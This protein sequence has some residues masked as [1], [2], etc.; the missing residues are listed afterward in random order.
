[1]SS[2]WI[3]PVILVPG[4]P[5]FDKTQ[6]PIGCIETAEGIYRIRLGTGQ[7][8]R[9]VRPRDLPEGW[10]LIS[11]Q[12]VS[13]DGKIR[14]TWDLG[15]RG[16]DRLLARIKVE[17][18]GLVPVALVEASPL[19]FG[20]KCDWK[21]GQVLLFDTETFG[22][23][24]NSG[25]EPLIEGEQS[26]GA[27]ATALNKPALVAG[28]VTTRCTLGRSYVTPRSDGIQFVAKQPADG[29]ILLP[30][31]SRQFEW[32]FAS[33]GKRPTQE[34]ELLG[35]LMAHFNKPR[36][37]H[38]PFATWCTW[39]SSMVW[40][41]SAN[42]ELERFVLDQ[43][44]ELQPYRPLGLKTVRV[45]EDAPYWGR[46]D[47][48]LITDGLPSGYPSIAKSAQAHGFSVGAWFDNTRSLVTTDAAQKHPGWF[49]KGPG[50]NPLRRET[51][52]CPG[53]WCKKSAF[54]ALTV[55]F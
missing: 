4:I 50:G 45:V 7:A 47:Y 22:Y 23:N 35:S 20:L 49:A 29:A 6:A 12:A 30:G 27:F 54:S 25:L 46:I 31:R 8:V 14:L 32:L 38:K 2:I 52:S 10:I 36:L 39:Y 19:S 21:G 11:R 15:S 18:L 9:V 55:S 40:P 5:F 3:L 37:K 48:P 43:L 17:N 34:L 51:G 33:L 44:K 26:G 1:M 16:D 24:R 53:M 42:G 13:S 41:K 28:F